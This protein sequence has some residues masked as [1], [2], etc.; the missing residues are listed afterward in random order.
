MLTLCTISTKFEKKKKKNTRK[1]NKKKNRSKSHRWKSLDSMGRTVRISVH[2]CT[3]YMKTNYFYKC[4]LIYHP[5]NCILNDLSRNIHKYLR[6]QTNSKRSWC[7][8]LILSCSI[9]HIRYIHILDTLIVE[10][11]NLLKDKNIIIYIKTE[12][13]IRSW[14]GYIEINI[15]FLT[16]S[17]KFIFIHSLRKR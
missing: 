13:K 1:I 9:L 15:Y 6:T 4:L 10:L 11:S 8:F 3:F 17:R 14:N 16:Y 12:K 5:E 7:Y 2:K